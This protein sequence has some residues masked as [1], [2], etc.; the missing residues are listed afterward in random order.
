MTPQAASASVPERTIDR[1]RFEA[2]ASELEAMVRAK[3]ESACSPV[4]SVLEL[5]LT[6]QTKE[7]AVSPSVV[8]ILGGSEQPTLLLFLSL[9]HI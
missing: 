5:F 6:P 9:I 4:M 1:E 3:P 8:R 7:P 2:P